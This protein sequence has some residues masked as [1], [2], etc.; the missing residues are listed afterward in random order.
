MKHLIYHFEH[1]TLGMI[2]GMLITTMTDRIMLTRYADYRITNDRLLLHELSPLN[3]SKHAPPELPLT[4]WIAGPGPSR[5]RAD[6]L[7]YERLK[8]YRRLRE[9][10]KGR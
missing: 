10:R 1:P 3:R 6:L 9:K 8:L 2:V 5:S 4:G 7:R